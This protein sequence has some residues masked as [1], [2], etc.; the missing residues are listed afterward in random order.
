MSHATENMSPA[1][2][3][4]ERIISSAQE[5]PSGSLAETLDQIRSIQRKDAESEPEAMITDIAL[6]LGADEAQV[7]AA[8]A[9]VNFVERSTVF[10]EKKRGLKEKFDEA[11]RKALLPVTTALAINMTPA[12][13]EASQ[14]KNP[15]TPPEASQAVNPESRELKKEEIFDLHSP[16]AIVGEKMKTLQRELSAEE[17]TLIKD[18]RQKAQEEKNEWIAVAGKEKTGRFHVEIKEV[19][20]A[21][22]ELIS[23]TIEE[24][25]SEPSINHT[26][27]AAMLDFSGL[28]PETI[29]GMI[30]PPSAVDIGGCMDNAGTDTVQRVVD[31]RGI[32]EYRCDEQHPFVATRKSLRENLGAAIK[33]V[34]TKYGVQDDDIE[35]ARSAAATTHPT[36]AVDSFLSELDKKYPGLEKSW[37]TALAEVAASSNDLSLSM[38]SYEKSA[39]V[40]TMASENLSEEDLSNKIRKFIQDSEKM[41]VHISYTPFKDFPKN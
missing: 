23:D 2:A 15:E 5:Q 34:H 30:M 31:S 35:Q 40:L 19:G 14:I 11:V 8:K 13:A 36:L 9:E 24:I 1:V 17:L 12:L 10:A 20:P 25:A 29:Q 7:K 38:L 32:W 6:R 18:F 28:S 16:L 26:H 37:Q 33:E 21:G 39:T 3:E 27:P 41:G 22:G 4:Q